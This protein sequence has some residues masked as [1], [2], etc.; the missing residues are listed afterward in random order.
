LKQV[1]ALIRKDL[2]LEWRLQHTF[3]G[4]LL[5]TASTIFILFIS[6]PKPEPAVWNSLFWITLLFMCI[7]A[8]AKSFLQETKGR[9]L[10]YQ[11]LVPP[12][13]FLIAKL[14][15]NTALM[16]LMSLLTLLLFS[17]FL[18]QAY[19]RFG[20]FIWMTL[21]GGVSLTLLFTLLAA[22]ASKANQNAA[23]MAVLGFPL[24]IPQLMLLLKLSRSAFGEVFRED[25]FWNMSIVLLSLD[26]MIFLASLILFP[27]LWKD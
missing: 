26:G 21:L 6:L 1:L 23:L 3:Y 14:L 2:L 10:Y 12:S 4:L 17:F 18:G 16:T 19:L 7:H 27:F 8:V 9:M 5:Y 11:L 25:A 20:Q 24:I 13:I 22:I 15:Y